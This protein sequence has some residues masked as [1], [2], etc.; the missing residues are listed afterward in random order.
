MTGSALVFWATKRTAKPSSEARL[1]STIIGESNQP[2]CWPSSNT[3]V[4][5]LNAS[6]IPAIPHQ[7][8]W[9]EGHGMQTCPLGAH[10]VDEVGVP[11][12]DGLVGPR[13]GRTKARGEDAWIRLGH[14]DLARIDDEIEGAEA[15]PLE[16]QLNG[17]VGIRDAPHDQPRITHPPHRGGCFA[18]G[19]VA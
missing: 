1:N 14:T 19:L 15:G 10:H 16:R 18:I 8:A 4:R 2:S 3:T 5:Q 17:A 12:V 7:S 6:V 11:D 13:P 9:I